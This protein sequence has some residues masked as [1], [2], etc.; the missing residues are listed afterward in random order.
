LGEVQKGSSA[1][2]Q[3]DGSEPIK[4][5]GPARQLEAV[6]SI[7][8]AGRFLCVNATLEAS[9]SYQGHESPP[10]PL[11]FARQLAPGI[12][13]LKLKFPTSTPAGVYLGSLELD[14]R[15]Q[16]FEADVKPRPKLSASPNS[17]ALRGGAGDQLS[18]ELTLVNG[19]NGDYD[20]PA[21]AAIGLFSDGGVEAALG[22][23]YRTRDSDGERWID[24]LG[25]NLTEE[26]GGLVHIRV[27]EGAGPLRPGE[28]RAIRLHLRLPE[29]LRMEKL[30]IGALEFG[31]LA[32]PLEVDTS[33]SFATEA[34][35]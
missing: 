11:V 26:H 16:R 25:A 23:A 10:Q 7:P 24:R 32:L 35:R 8:D 29:Q 21:A 12:F 28:M 31:E 2:A 17:L 6:V 9:S 15:R 1:L 19:G 30:Y 20:I 5:S 27:V 22:K 34:L 14:G 18:V 3:S 13:R 4:F 33:K